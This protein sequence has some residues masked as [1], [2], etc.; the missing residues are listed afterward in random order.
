MSLADYMMRLGLAL[1]GTN[2]DLTFLA[3][4]ESKGKGGEEQDDTDPD[5]S[6]EDGDDGESDEDGDEQDGDDGDEQDDDGED[7]D[8]GMDGDEGGEP[9]G[10]P[11][12]TTSG[13]GK[14]GK[15]N[16]KGKPSDED[17]GGVGSGGGSTVR[18]DK[19]GFD[20]AQFAQD[21]LAAMERGDEAGVKDLANALTEAIRA[22]QKAQDGSVLADEVLW[23][24]VSTAKDKV[25]VVGASAH[26]HN[27][28]RKLQESVRRE[29]SFLRA[30]L[31][32]KFL[33]A[34]QPRVLHGV[35]Q[36]E[37]LSERRL[38]DTWVEV[39][40]GIAPTR[41]NTRTV[42][43]DKVSIAVAMVIDQS[44]SM[45]Q[46]KTEAARAL[47]AICAPLDE[48]GCPVL[49]V[50]F[51][52]GIEHTS[53]ESEMSV[54]PSR[55]YHRRTSVDIDIFKGWDE[56]VRKCL[57]RFTRLMAEG[58]TPMSD[59]IQFALQALS[60]RKE[61]H[62]ILLVITDGEP[63]WGHEPIIRRQQRLAREAGIALVGV[64]IDYG[65]TSV[66]TLYD[67]HVLV[68]DV[69]KL[70]EQLLKTINDLVFPRGPARKVTLDGTMNTRVAHP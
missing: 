11:S 64:G 36:G 60:T 13:K 39:L 67:R 25:V 12:D 57:G 62:R 30:R 58:S 68:G 46:R 47:T 29:V 49:A 53:P 18:D 45:Q 38:A 3:P 34:K 70:P 35:K 63:D 41:P 43:R 14:E 21:L 69:S 61:R 48:V 22:E 44:G 28:G 6:D 23:N 9:S 32:N 56:P 65:C 51:R 55:P 20:P 5:P 50:G 2:A 42:R 17:A 10:V 27:M 24:P 31:R 37:A 8:D 16:T 40:S 26:D 33:E 66:K 4:P 52:S 59:G 19:A 7:G 1:A 54:D 15:S